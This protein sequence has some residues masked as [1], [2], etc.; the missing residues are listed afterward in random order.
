MPLPVPG[1]DVPRPDLGPP[2][3]RSGPE[4]P[5][6]RFGHLQSVTKAAEGTWMFRISR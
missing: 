5:S 2:P 1:L 3:W 4:D 6:G